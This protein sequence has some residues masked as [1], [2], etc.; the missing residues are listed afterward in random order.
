[1][2]VILGLLTGG[3]LAGQSLIQSAELRSVTTEQSRWVTAAQS[4]RDKYFGI[5]GDFSSATRFWGRQVNASD[6]VTNSSASV[7]TSGACDGD[8]SGGLGFAPAAAKAG[9]NLQFWRQLTLAGLIEG[10]YSGVAGPSDVLDAN[11][12]G[13]TV[14]QARLPNAGWWAETRDGLFGNSSNYMLDYRNRLVFGA[15]KAASATHGPALTPEEAWNIDSKLDDGKPATGKVIAF[16]WN[17]ECAAADDGTNANTD[18]VA[19]YRLS[20][21]STLCAL[22]FRHAF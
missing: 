13:T 12:L 2:L 6:C 3:I 21:K 17:S 9:E 15:V 10:T 7:N 11:P 22:S 4:F 19:S 20:D 16:H 5:P 8:A 1:M 14:P 18:L